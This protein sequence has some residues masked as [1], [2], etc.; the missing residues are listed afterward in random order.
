MK[1]KIY[2]SLS[3]SLLLPSLLP[4]LLSF[5]PKKTSETHFMLSYRNN[6]EHCFIN[7]FPKMINA[8]DLIC[9]IFSIAQLSHLLLFHHY[10]KTTEQLT[11]ASNPER[12]CLF[13][14][15]E[16]TLYNTNSTAEALVQ[17]RATLIFTL[18]RTFQ[19]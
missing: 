19:I 2:Y 5:L 10:L 9:S 7:T 15:R 13:A 18:R 1:A 6:Y 4:S 12:S 8:Q 17:G 14:K 16:Y 3:L 11:D